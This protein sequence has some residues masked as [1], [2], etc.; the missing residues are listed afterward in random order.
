L[1]LF[2]ESNFVLEIALGQQD[3]TAAE[4]LLILAE[5]AQLELALP[6]F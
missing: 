5:Q 6:A 2:V 1:T 3:S 4:R